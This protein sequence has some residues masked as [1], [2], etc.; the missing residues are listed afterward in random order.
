MT[1]GAESSLC[2]ADLRH[3]LWATDLGNHVPKKIE[4]I[5]QAKTFTVVGLQRAGGIHIHW[6]KADSL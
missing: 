2:A 3:P 4:L 6:L 5:P 1:I